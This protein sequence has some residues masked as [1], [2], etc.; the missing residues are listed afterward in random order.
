MHELKNMT[1]PVNLFYIRY[2][3]NQIEIFQ[4]FLWK[5]YKLGKFQEEKVQFILDHWEILMLNVYISLLE[6]TRGSFSYTSI[7]ECFPLMKNS[8]EDEVI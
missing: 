4:L 5:S 7:P 8:G 6:C 3:I 1:S 2:L